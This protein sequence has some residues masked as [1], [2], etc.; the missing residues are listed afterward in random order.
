MK[1][2]FLLVA[3]TAFIGAGYASPIA[4]ISKAVTVSCDKDKCEKSCKKECKKANKEC[5][6][7]KKCCATKSSGTKSCSKSAGAKKSCCKK[8]TA[9]KAACGAKKAETPSQVK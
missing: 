7:G 4:S 2:L 9:V 1:K 8:S 3:I 5:K 6:K